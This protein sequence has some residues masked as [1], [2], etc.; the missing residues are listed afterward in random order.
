MNYRDRCGNTILSVWDTDDLLAR[1]YSTIPGRLVLKLVSL[2][3]IASLIRKFL[4]TKY[5][6]HLIGTYNNFFK[7]KEKEY[8]AQ[9]YNSFNDYFTRRI[10]SSFRPMAMDDHIL[11]S[12]CDGKLLA[13]KIT[14]QS[15]FT[16]K[17]AE[18]SL[19]DLL[20]DEKLAMR[21]ID[22]YCVIVRIALEDNHRYSYIDNGYK[23][24]NRHIN[25]RLYNVNTVVNNYKKVYWE[26]S[27]EYTLMRTENFGNVIQMEVGTL[28]IGLINN[29]HER[30]SFRKGEE[31]GR[32]EFGGSTIIL[33]F[34]NGKVEMDPDLLE[35]TRH[36]FETLV[37]LGEQIG[38]KI[39]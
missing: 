30:G 25:G 38:K 18:Y 35:N 29:Y 13:Y 8:I 36:N 33:L 20:K 2:P 22:G 14:S 12:P 3:E 37:K 27:R 31:K 10:K 9:E 7:I 39:V 28:F 5:S 32:F 19:K 15:R 6:C 34:E 16:V 17:K 26:N 1:F 11:V 4:S 24:S 23:T 21:Y